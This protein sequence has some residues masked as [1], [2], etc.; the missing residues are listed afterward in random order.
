MWDYIYPLHM[1]MYLC[2]WLSAD[3]WR[4]VLKNKRQGNWNDCV[5][6][7]AR[8]HR[9]LIDWFL[10]H[11]ICSPYNFNSYFLPVLLE[12]NIHNNN[13]NNNNTR[14]KKAKTKKVVKSQAPIIRSTNSFI[15]VFVQSSV[16]ICIAAQAA[17][18]TP[19]NNILFF[20]ILFIGIC[21]GSVQSFF[22]FIFS[23]FSRYHFLFFPAIS[24]PKSSF[25]SLRF[26]TATLTPTRHHQFQKEGSSKKK[27]TESG[28]KNWKRTQVHNG[29]ENRKKNMWKRKKNK[30]D[31]YRKI[32]LLVWS[33][34]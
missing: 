16:F 21:T 1:C 33:V 20:P 10:F 32:S 4:D 14:V 18:T 7:V 22:F 34:V 30:N 8:K 31:S 29:A 13:T 9:D 27:N 26:H 5:T 2:V 15:F 28:K 12:Y 25:F 3:T 6:S 23:F 19:L 24:F 17:A 11:T